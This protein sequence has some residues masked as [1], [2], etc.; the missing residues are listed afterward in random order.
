MSKWSLQNLLSALHDDIEQRLERA[1]KVYQHP[2]VK[3]DASEHVWRDLL[4]SYLPKRYEVATA[5]VIDST[6]AFSDPR[7]M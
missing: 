4:A 6:G 2:T 5:H 7:S 1:R 3:G